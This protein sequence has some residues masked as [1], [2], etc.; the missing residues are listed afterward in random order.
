[1]ITQSWVKIVI[2]ELIPFKGDRFNAERNRRLHSSW[3]WF[4]ALIT[5]CSAV[6]AGLSGWLLNNVAEMVVIKYRDATARIRSFAWKAYPADHCL[7]FIIFHSM[8]LV[9]A[10]KTYFHY[11]HLTRRSGTQQSKSKPSKSVIFRQKME[12]LWEVEGPNKKCLSL[13]PDTVLLSTPPQ[14]PW[15]S[16]RRQDDE[17]PNQTQ[18]QSQKKDACF[19]CHRQGHWAQDCPSKS[20]TP[21]SNT[22]RSLPD[23]GSD[24][25]SVPVLRCHCG[26]AYKTAISRSQDNPGRRYYVRECECRGNIETEQGG[27]F[28]RYIWYDEHVEDLWAPTCEC[29]AGACTINFGV[30]RVKD[31]TVMTYN[32]YYTCRIRM[33]HGACGFLKFITPPD[34]SMEKSIQPSVLSPNLVPQNNVTHENEC[35]IPN[36]EGHRFPRSRSEIHSRQ[37][38]FENQMSA[39]A[40]DSSNTC[41]VLI[42][43]RCVDDVHGWVGRL[44]FPPPRLLV[45][46]PPRHFFCCIFPL[47]DPILVSEYVDISDSGS[48]RSIPHALDNKVDELSQNNFRNDTKLMVVPLKIPSRKRSFTA[49]QEDLT[50]LV[51]KE[52]GKKLIQLM[53]PPDN[54]ALPQAANAAFDVSAC[55]SSECGP[56]AESST[57]TNQPASIVI[58]L[59]SVVQENCNLQAPTE[60]DIV[61][62][63]LDDIAGLH[64]E[65]LATLRASRPSSNFGQSIRKGASHLKEMRLQMRKLYHH[66]ETETLKLE[67][68]FLDMTKDLDAYEEVSE[69]LKL[70]L[71][72]ERC[73]GREEPLETWSSSSESSTL[74]VRKRQKVTGNYG[75]KTE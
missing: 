41:K 67:T 16:H 56:F 4:S 15:A 59:G 1:M 38:E 72:E 52:A 70:E 11:I 26:V 32:M 45:D 14:K 17:T 47:F 13:D 50:S 31:G 57:N 3:F 43:G 23:Q 25:H 30:G 5:G 51:L 48:S 21:K 69:T 75:S 65:A 28:K 44:A 24:V 68:F 54:D 64:S 8:V 40:A 12:M 19:I 35:P 18:T 10:S 37:I 66:W 2:G 34:W 55:P 27:L 62:E 20:K 29:G 53:E 74:D 71:R 36:L 73:M 61:E 33:G 63:S 42:L 22:Q 49:V 60:H 9:F 58:E 7:G 39:A 46:P 6:C